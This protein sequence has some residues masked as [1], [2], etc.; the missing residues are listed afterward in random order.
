MFMGVVYAG[1]VAAFEPCGRTS[2]HWLPLR[3]CEAELIL[4]LMNARS[5]SSLRKAKKD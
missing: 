1:F 3:H 2:N 4:S 5:L